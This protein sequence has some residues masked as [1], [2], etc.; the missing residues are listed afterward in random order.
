MCVCVCVGGIYL[1]LGRVRKASRGSDPG[2]EVQRSKICLGYRFWM[3]QAER[4]AHAKVLRQKPS[5][6]WGELQVVWSM[7]CCGAARDESENVLRGQFIKSF[8]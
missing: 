8:V 2:A 3:C 4:T 6:V 7:V 5:H 1:S